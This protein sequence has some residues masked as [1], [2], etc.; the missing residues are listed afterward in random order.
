MP[1]GTTTLHEDP[2]IRHSGVSVECKSNKQD[3]SVNNEIIYTVTASDGTSAEYK[4]IFVDSTVSAKEIL[5]F[6]F[7]KHLNSFP[8]NLHNI[9]IYLNIYIEGEKLFISF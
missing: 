8:N 1:A 5:V 4:V 2:R 9:S 7:E 6:K 3:Y